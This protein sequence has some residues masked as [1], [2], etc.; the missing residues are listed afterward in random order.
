MLKESVA[1]VRRQAWS[2][3]EHIIIDGGSSDGTRAWVRTQPYL[4]WIDGPDCGLYDALNK[5][6]AKASGDVIALLNSDDILE[7][8]ALS[9]AAAAFESYPEVDAVAGSSVLTEG[10][11]VVEEFNGQREI[12]LDPT[13]VLL[14]RCLPNPRFFRRSSLAKLGG[15]SLDYQLVADRDF[16]LRFL[17]AGGRTGIIPQCVYR[18]RRHEGSLTF[19][20]GLARS[21][22]LRRELVRLGARWGGDSN[23]TPE[24]RAAARI[25]EGRQRAALALDMMKKRSPVEVVEILAV[26]NGKLSLAPMTS[27]ARALVDFIFARRAAVSR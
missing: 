8:G 3:V 5:G 27:I 10:D 21:R 26:K 13:T 24:T 4:Q 9:A 11:M 15:F 18:Y 7:V 16:L 12:D 20:R 22:Q 25:L 14:G 6:L 2:N 17:E 23:A 19:D 1:S